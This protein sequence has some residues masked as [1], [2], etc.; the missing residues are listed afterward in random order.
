MLFYMSVSDF[1]QSNEAFC[2]QTAET[3]FPFPV[4]HAFYAANNIWASQWACVCVAMSR[5]HYSFFFH[6]FHWPVYICFKPTTAEQKSQ[7]DDNTPGLLFRQIN[8]Y[9]W[10]SAPAPYSD[11]IRHNSCRLSFYCGGAIINC[12]NQPSTFYRIRVSLS[13]SKHCQFNAEISIV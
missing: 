3:Q 4:I 10:L 2:L 5:R 8:K 13:L 12:L 7:S 11:Y 6:K 1:V 9:W